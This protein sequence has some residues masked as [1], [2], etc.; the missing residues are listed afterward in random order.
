MK[1]QFLLYLLLAFS[2]FVHGQ[3]IMAGKIE[4]E[5]KP[6]RFAE[7]LNSSLQSFQYK[8]EEK[9]IQLNYFSQLEEPL[10]LIGDPYRL[11][12][13]LNNLLN[14]A[15]KFTAEGG[16]IEIGAEIIDDKIQVKVSD[17]GVG[18]A[19][20]E[21]EHLFHIDSKV[22]RKGTNNEDGSGLGLILC[23]EFVNINKGKLWVESTPGKGST[24][25]FTLPTYSEVN[26]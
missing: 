24:F 21:L 11:I 3:F 13:I 7:K 2:C 19:Q 6:F 18:L 9:G 15:I 5:Q 20:A 17:T 1:K 4:F 8:A 16:K 23:R 25:S 14:N 10:V 12:Q 22:K 26:A